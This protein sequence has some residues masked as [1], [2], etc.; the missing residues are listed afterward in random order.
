VINANGPVI[1]L[2]A[3][4][5]NGDEGGG[6]QGL[7]SW[8]QVLINGARADTK[9]PKGAA[10]SSGTFGT[11]VEGLKPADPGF[12]KY[13]YNS[14]NVAQIDN[15]LAQN[16]G[17]GTVGKYDAGNSQ[18]PGEKFNVPLFLTELFYLNRSDPTSVQAQIA[19]AQISLNDQAK[20]LENYWTA[21]GSGSSTSN[22]N[23]QTQ[24]MGYNFFEFND[25][26]SAGPKYMGLYLLGTNIT[27]QNTGVTQNA[28]SDYGLYY[29]GNLALPVPPLVA[30]VIDN[31]GGTLVAALASLWQ[32]K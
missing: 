17:G 24:L 14:E 11:A 7:P 9:T 8:F 2:T 30:E 29:F 27:T 22:P 15:G 3:S 23:S 1:P 12:F 19:S 25:E 18:W 20:V 10:N 32:G 28:G 21:L 26:P 16:P 31:S 5:S 4:W 6:S 13:Y